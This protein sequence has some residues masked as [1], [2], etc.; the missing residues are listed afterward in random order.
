MLT[1]SGP[2]LL[3]FGVAR[4]KEESQAPGTSSMAAT[5]TSIPTLS[6]VPAFAAP[7]QAPEQLAGAAPDAR[8]DIF[9]FGTILYEMVTGRPAFQEKTVALLSAAI[10][11]VDPEAATT[12]QPAVP[13]ALDH[14]IR[15]CLSKDP[16][17][18]LQT[19]WDLMTQLQWIAEGGSQ[20]GIPAPAV[21][22]R[23]NQDR[24][25]WA[26]VAAVLVL[27]VGITPST[28]ARF[29]SVAEPEEVRFLASR[30]SDRAT[31]VRSHQTAAG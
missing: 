13:P 28:L 8:S 31:P 22:G 2:K 5:R 3:D 30:P 6:A 7:Y 26:A 20:I 29:R 18:R 25:V 24:I 1:A 19:A 14:I 17:Q 12:L 9:A 21:A 16:R 15:R 27:T 23:T 11:S 10:L 4:L